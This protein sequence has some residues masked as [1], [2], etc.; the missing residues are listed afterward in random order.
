MLSIRLPVD[1]EERLAALAKQRR[2]DIDTRMRG[3]Y[4]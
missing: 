4:G 2:A 3:S 1:I